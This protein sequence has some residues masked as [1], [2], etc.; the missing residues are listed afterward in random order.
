MWCPV[1]L[2]RVIGLKR[3]NLLLAALASTSLSLSAV[4]TAMADASIVI[5]ASTPVAQSDSG[6]PPPAT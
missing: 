2:D 5:D 6:M 4:T 3:R 1:H